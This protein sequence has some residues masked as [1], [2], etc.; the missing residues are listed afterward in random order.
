MATCPT[1]GRESETEQ[2]PVGE[3]VT[4]FGCASCRTGVIRTFAHHEQR[5]AERTSPGA[6]V[7]RPAS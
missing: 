7:A 4:V 1:C 5:E 6:Q 3:T 2:M